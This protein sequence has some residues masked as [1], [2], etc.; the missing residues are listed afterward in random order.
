MM[1][2]ALMFLFG[3]AQVL[4][5]VR[6]FQPPGGPDYPAWFQLLVGLVIALI[7]AHARGL[8]VRIDKAETRIE[9]NRTSAEQQINGLQRALDREYHSKQETNQMF[10]R[11]ENAMTAVHRRLDLMGAP[12]SPAA[13]KYYQQDD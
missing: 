5:Q 10:L 9:Q 3:A 12:Q 6:D 1:V 13:P 7:G 2:G 4:A 8:G 11:I